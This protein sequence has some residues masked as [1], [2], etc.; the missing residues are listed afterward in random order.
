MSVISYMKAGTSLGID[1]I[2]INILKV[3]A[4]KDFGH[5]QKSVLTHQHCTTCLPYAKSRF[6]AMS[7]ILISS[8]RRAH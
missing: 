7:T 3:V 6:S 8:Y 4:N 1:R 5:Q 2:L